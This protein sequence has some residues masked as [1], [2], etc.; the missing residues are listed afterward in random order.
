MARKSER[1]TQGR[2]TS[3]AEERAPARKRDPAALRRE[4]AIIA[5]GVDPADPRALAPVRTRIVRAILLWE[6]GAELRE[7]RDWQPMLETVVQT[8]EANEQ[9][10]A[11]FARLI[12]DLQ[13]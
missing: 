13:R 6:F 1:S 9:H 2:Q 4:L 7:H 10:R 8:L 12:R 5:K 11:A 3:R